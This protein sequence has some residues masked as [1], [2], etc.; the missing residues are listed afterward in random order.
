MH[1]IPSTRAM[2]AI[3]VI[4][5]AAITY[6]LMNFVWSIAPWEA[7]VAEEN[8]QSKIQHVVNSPDGRW[9]AYLI[10]ERGMD[11]THSYEMYV[12]RSGDSAS[13]RYIGEASS[14][15]GPN[16]GDLR[17]S[18]DSGTVSGYVDS[19]AISALVWGMSSRG[20]FARR[21]RT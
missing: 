3:G 4:G 6:V 21:S 9:T 1:I 17:W 12:Q 13:R 7:A 16:G 14:M 8:F 20:W 15:G 11:A 18:A 10:L 5:S 2:L 19:K